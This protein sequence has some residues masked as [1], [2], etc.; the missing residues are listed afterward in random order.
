MC[1]IKTIY[2]WSTNAKSHYDSFL[3]GKE[4]GGTVGKAFNYA[5]I[6]KSLAN[7]AGKKI[8]VNMYK[9]S[10]KQIMKDPK[11]RRKFFSG[12]QNALR[13][14]IRPT[15]LGSYDEAL[16]YITGK[17]V[18]NLAPESAKKEAVQGA[19]RLFKYIKDTLE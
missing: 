7:Y 18:D 1:F 4:T 9:D 5:L 14:S 17:A 6:A 11:R 15:E 12:F 10:L 3:S 19:D 2:E 13:P 8:T 16:G